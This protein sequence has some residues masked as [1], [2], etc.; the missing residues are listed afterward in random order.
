MALKYKVGQRV[1]IKRGLFAGRR[2][3]IIAIQSKDVWGPGSGKRFGISYRT[4]APYQVKID[5][6]ARPEGF[7]AA[8][9]AGR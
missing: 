2:G 9:L 3:T 1:R 6:V 4:M 8:D 7:K 5:G